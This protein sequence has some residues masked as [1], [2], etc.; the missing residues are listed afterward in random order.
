VCVGGTAPPNT[1]CTSSS[2]CAGGGRCGALF[3]D[4]RPLLGG[5]GPLVLARGAVGSGFCQKTG[6]S[7]SADCG[8]DG[9]CVSYAF[10]ARTPVPLDGLTGTDD[11]FAFSVSEPVANKVLNGD[12]EALGRVLVIQDRDTGRTL[13]IGAAGSDAR[14]IL[15]T[16]EPPF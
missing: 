14:A 10:E 9:P 6:T 2:Q 5:G 7:C 4:F 3:A 15:I 8:V 12:G 11:V 16:Q 13:P 1:S